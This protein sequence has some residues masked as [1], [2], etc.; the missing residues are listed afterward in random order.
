MMEY[1]GML[2]N[3][4]H[5]YMGKLFQDVVVSEPQK[6]PIIVGINKNVIK[7]KPK[8]IGY[9][10][11]NYKLQKYEKPTKPIAQDPKVYLND[12]FGSKSEGYKQ[13]IICV[14]LKSVCLILQRIKI[15]PLIRVDI[16]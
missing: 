5:N 4:A 9:G 2:L 1:V 3:R 12:L 15:T 14:I 8:G 13:E 10:D 11:T 16:K 7:G 6:L